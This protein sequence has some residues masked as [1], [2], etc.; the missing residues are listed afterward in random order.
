MEANTMKRKWFG[1]PAALFGAVALL[2]AVG[3][4][5]TSDNGNKGAGENTTP[6]QAKAPAA[7]PAPAPAEPKPVAVGTAKARNETK[8]YTIEVLVPDNVSA[9]AENALTV[10]VK[11]KGEWHFNLDFPTSVKVEAPAGMTVAKNKQGLD[12]AVSKSEEDGASWAIK[13]TPEKAGSGTLK[14]NV[15]FAVCTETTCDPKKETLALQLD[16]K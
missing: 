5:K 10:V 3:C 2:G 1:R 11:P 15:K 12:D 13:V 4:S 9:G 16:A 8:E 6:T 14:C 7:T